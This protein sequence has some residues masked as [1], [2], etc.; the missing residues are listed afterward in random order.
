[1]EVWD[2]PKRTIYLPMIPFCMVNSRFWGSGLQDGSV[3]PTVFSAFPPSCPSQSLNT[4]ESPLAFL[5]ATQYNKGKGF[6]KR[7][8]D[9]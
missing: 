8:K 4:T 2:F 7:G 9:I 3:D 5:A 6:S 1:M